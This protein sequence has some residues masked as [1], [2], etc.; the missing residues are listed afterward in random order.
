MLG[1]GAAGHESAVNR[2]QTK[3]TKKIVFSVPS[4]AFRI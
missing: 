2:V 1:V 4:F 3:G